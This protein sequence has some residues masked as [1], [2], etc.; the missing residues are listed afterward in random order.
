MVSLIELKLCVF[1]IQMECVSIYAFKLFHPFVCESFHHTNIAYEKGEDL[2]TGGCFF[3][4]VFIM[5]FTILNFNRG[6]GKRMI[7]VFE[8]PRIEEKKRGE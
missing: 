1:V 4:L 3:Y 7:L 8:R 2:A 6:D 5:R